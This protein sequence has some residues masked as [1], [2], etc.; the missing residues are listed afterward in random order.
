MICYMIWSYDIMYDIKLWYHTPSYDNNNNNIIYNIMVSYMTSCMTII[1]YMISYVIYILSPRWVMLIRNW[2]WRYVPECIYQAALLCLSAVF[3]M[4]GVAPVLI[5]TYGEY[6]IPVSLHC[7]K[8]VLQ[9]PE[10][11]LSSDARG[12]PK[13][14]LSNKV[15]K[16]FWGTCKLQPAVIDC[17]TLTIEIIILPIL[18]ALRWKVSSKRQTKGT[19]LSLWTLW[20]LLQ[21]KEPPGQLT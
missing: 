7:I 6:V 1:L 12:I 19:V 11:I 21:G 8:K 18:V 20:S 2:R 15:L 3:A 10:F 17:S 9:K 14:L 4:G 13:H 5:S 16:G